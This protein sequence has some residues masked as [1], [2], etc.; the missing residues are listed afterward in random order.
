M[1]HRIFLAGASGAI[2]RRLTS[3]LC[4]AGHHVFGTTRV[5]A[6]AE[7]LRALGA[8]PVIVDV[9][10][11]AALLSAV[12]TSRPEVVIH[13]LTDLPTSLDP[14]QMGQAI[15][16]NAR[17]RDEG[18]Q[19]LVRAAL[20]AGARRLV[21]QSIAWA[22]TPGPEPH[23]ESDPLDVDA[24]GDRQ[25]T[26]R[27]VTALEDWTLHSPPLEGIVL[28]YGRLYGPGTHSEIPSTSASVHVDAAAYAALRAIDHGMPGIF[29]IAQPN[30]HVTSDKARAQLGWT[31]DFRYSA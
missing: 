14:S 22:Y 5:A 13:E 15:V 23:L 19:N 6:K 30:P 11:G 20:A 17:I 21:A 26:V 10:D 12:T 3:L 16:R 25:I 18:T 31:A 7:Q 27:G 24:Q 2:G 1:N 9:F 29:N 4:G 28:R 8:E